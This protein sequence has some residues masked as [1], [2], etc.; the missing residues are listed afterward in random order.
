MREVI[1]HNNFFAPY[2]MAMEGRN[3]VGGFGYRFGFQNQETEREITGSASHSFFRHRISDNRL[4]RFFSVDLLH[5]SYPWNSSYAFS[6]NDVIRSVELEGLEKLAL[7]GSVPTEQIYNK[8]REGMPGNTGYTKGHIYGFAQQAKQLKLKYGF[9]AHKVQSGHDLLQKMQT[10]T[11]NHG[12][13]THLFFFGHGSHKGWFFKWNEGFYVKNNLQYGGS[14]D[15]TEL[16]NKIQN[17][18]IQFSESSIIF[19][20]ACNSGGNWGKNHQTCMAAELAIVTGATVI[21]ADGHVEMEDDKTPKYDGKFTVRDGGNFYKFTR[22]QSQK[23]DTAG[24]PITDSDGNAVMEYSV[25]VE[26]IGTTVSA[27]DYA[28]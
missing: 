8:D 27:D 23:L 11:T 1:N 20:D 18:D 16:K 26:N 9:H 21:A 2:G 12:E 5:K 6:E 24:N 15:L 28:K 19:I 3:F 7:S 14:T 10:E 22:M 4:G 17:K 13:I 25:K